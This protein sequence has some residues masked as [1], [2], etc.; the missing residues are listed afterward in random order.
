MKQILTLR[1]YKAAIA[2]G[3]VILMITSCKKNEVLPEQTVVEQTEVTDLQASI[4]VKGFSPIVSSIAD[5]SRFLF[6]IRVY[7]S[8]P[9]S[10]KFTWLVRP[11][12]GNNL[13]LSQDSFYLAGKK[14]LPYS[15]NG[16]GS[17]QYSYLSIRKF[18]DYS[19][20]TG[21]LYQLP[22]PATFQTTATF[23]SELS[24]SVVMNTTTYKRTEYF[25]QAET[26]WG[27]PWAWR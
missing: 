27:T 22:P 2:M 24:S 11:Y 1:G 21:T 14:F 25:P 15:L 5:T 9:T 17:W 3:I 8:E 18:K 6:Q 20:I 4:D 16:S 19:S 7:S 26:V 23:S 12:S 13:I 10:I